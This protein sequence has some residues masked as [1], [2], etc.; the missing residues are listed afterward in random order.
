MQNEVLSRPSA[1]LG[2]KNSPTGGV[3]SL[4]R[5]AREIT[6]RGNDMEV[7]TSREGIKVFEVSKKVIAVIP[8]GEGK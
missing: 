5:I 2:A 6:A 3:S 7:R 4:D 8:A 1:A